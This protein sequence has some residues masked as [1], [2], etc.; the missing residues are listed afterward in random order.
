MY[1]RP[2]HSG[3]TFPGRWLTASLLGIFVAA[4]LLAACGGDGAPEPLVAFPKDE[5]PH[6]DPIEWWYFNGLLTDDRGNQYSYHYVTFQSQGIDTAVPHLLQASLGDHTARVHLTGEKPVISP[7]KLDAAGV[8]VSISGWEMRGDGTT[9]NLKFDLGGYTLDLQATSERRP[10]LHDGD[11]LI[12]LGPAGNMF[13]YSRTRLNI[14]GFIETGPGAEGTHRA[15]TGTSWMDHQWGEVSGQQV[16]W[17]WTSI[18]LDDGTDLMAVELWDPNGHQQFARY[19]TFVFTDGTARH[20]LEEDFSITASD[21]WASPETGI[22]YPSVWRVEVNSLDLAL[23]LTPVLENSEFGSSKFTNAAYWE[24]EVTVSGTRNGDG[25]S[26]R[27]FVELVGYD[28]RQLE[29]PVSP[30]GRR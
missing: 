23:D 12:H 21:S 24:G 20:L 17:D 7:V 11:G 5:G 28:P 29:A 8:D 9:Y 14:S 30:Q 6:E 22:V 10:V 1:R 15:V 26:G 25:V 27:G 13:Y 18:Q 3:F 2:K 16:G 4:A 19:G